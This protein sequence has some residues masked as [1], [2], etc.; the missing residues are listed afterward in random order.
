VAHAL[1]LAGFVHM[2]RRDPLAGL[3]TGERLVALGNEHDFAV[4]NVAGRVL[5][6]WA[7][8]LLGAPEEEGLAEMREATNAYRSL[9]GVM[10]GPFLVSLAD[11]E[12][13]AHHFDR[14]EATLLQAE[15]VIKHRGEQVWVGSVLRSRGDVAAT[16]PLADFATAERRYA[17]ALAI[18]HRVGARSLQLRV[19]KGLARLWHRHG[20][21]KEARELLAPTIGLFTEGFDTRDL[22]EAKALLERMSRGA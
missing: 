2:M 21:A 17:E 19:T 14:A 7:R 11:S 10:A 3:E 12:R 20:K 1:W 16:R 22:I 5:R 13:R 9:A 8:A 18:A 4:Y 6:G 15:E